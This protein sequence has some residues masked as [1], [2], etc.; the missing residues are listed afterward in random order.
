MCLCN[1][2]RYIG[3]H[4]FIMPPKNAK[5]RKRRKKCKS[6]FDFEVLNEPETVDWYHLEPHGHEGRRR[7]VR[8]QVSV[9]LDETESAQPLTLGQQT[10]SKPQSSQAQTTSDANVR[11]VDDRGQEFQ[12]GND[13][14][15]RIDED[16]VQEEQTG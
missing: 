8:S 12:F 13:L 10:H 1:F 11:I 7:V 9:T 16:S 14:E 6:F 3:L 15:G 2:S 5:D 4:L